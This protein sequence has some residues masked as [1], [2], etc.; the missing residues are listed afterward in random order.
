MAVGDRIKR[1]RQFR[2]ITMKELGMAVGF[3]ESTADVRIAQYENNSREPKEELLKKIARALDVNWY[4]LRDPADYTD[5][6]LLFAFFDWEEQRAG[7]NLQRI[8]DESDPV[9]VEERVAVT[10]GYSMLNSFMMEWFERKQQVLR[11]EITWDEYREW[12][13]NWPDT[14]DVYYGDQHRKEWRKKE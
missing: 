9:H 10:F 6:D 13:L 1:V 4:S 3:S 5:D 8:M 12:K 2:K 11:G 7:V 14:S